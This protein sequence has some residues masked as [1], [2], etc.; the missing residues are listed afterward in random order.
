[1][2][3]TTFPTFERRFVQAI[4]VAAGLGSD[5]FDRPGTIVVPAVAREGSRMAVVYGIGRA[6][7]VWCDPAVAD[8]VAVLGDES[9]TF[10][11]EQVEEWAVTV[12]AEFA[13][14]AWS[15][16]VDDAGLVDPEMVE[17]HTFR[18]LDGEA[19][20]DRALIEGLVAVC[21]EDDA[22]YAEIDMDDLDPLLAGLID[23]AGELVGFAGGLPW[24][25]DEAFWDI[26]V[27]SHVERR[28]RGL[29][30]SVVAGISRE[31]LSRGHLPLYR[32]N[33]DRAP[34]RRLALS[35]GFREVLSLAAVRFD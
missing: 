1:M 5:R 10:P 12:G 21:G 35:L 27:L 2:A 7:L 13:G 23:G 25:N 4:A 33:W 9:V 28:S 31:I 26:G 24:E 8:Q 22:E 32:C 30:R 20:G 15:H 29:G 11:V 3:D 18:L 19:D 17:G 16:L 34:S 14:G 6:S